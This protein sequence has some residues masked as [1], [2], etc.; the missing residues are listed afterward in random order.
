MHEENGTLKRRE[1]LTYLG[2]APLLLLLPKLTMLDPPMAEPIYPAY[3]VISHPDIAEMW[4]EDE[5][6]YAGFV[7]VQASRPSI[8]RGFNEEYWT[9]KQ[10]WKMAESTRRFALTPDG[11]RARQLAKDFRN[12]GE[13][14]S[15]EEMRF[16]ESP[17][18]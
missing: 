15:V 2:T 13:M 4:A 5:A 6:L 3:T 18:L 14:G 11:H 9:P 16:I 17:T 10:R 7:R 12:A 1:F 8:C